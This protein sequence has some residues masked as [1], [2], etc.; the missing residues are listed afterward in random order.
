MLDKNLAVSLNFFFDI[1]QS[2]KCLSILSHNITI[3]FLLFELM[4][5]FLI[6]E[7]SSLLSAFFIVDAL[8]TFLCRGVD[9]IGPMCVLFLFSFFTLSV[10][11]F[12]DFLEDSVNLESVVNSV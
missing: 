12:S 1:S 7:L 4:S 10:L 5:R 3:D 8:S 6:D 9:C 2:F 11:L